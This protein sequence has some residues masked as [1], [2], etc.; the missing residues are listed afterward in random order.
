MLS[1]AHKEKEILLKK[2]C[3]Y[4]RGARVESCNNNFVLRYE[5]LEGESRVFDETGRVEIIDTDKLL[6]D[7]IKV[8]A[9]FSDEDEVNNVVILSFQD[10]V[11]TSSVYIEESEIDRD[12]VKA[13]IE[14]QAID[15]EDEGY[16][17]HFASHNEEALDEITGL[18]QT[19]YRMARSRFQAVFMDREDLSPVMSQGDA[20]DAPE[21]D[22]PINNLRAS[23]KL[24]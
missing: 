11:A 15:R 14:E 20:G 6:L 2:C 19:I 4:L 24:I 10:Y 13:L 18:L 22:E 5:L 16:I 3:S 17:L 23:L 12:F 7:S 21:V 8:N 1:E 9:I